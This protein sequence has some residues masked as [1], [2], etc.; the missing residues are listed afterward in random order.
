MKKLFLSIIV[1]GVTNLTFA[2]NTDKALARVRYSFSH[3]QDTTQKDK[4]HTE[5]MLLVIGKNASVY[6]S[7]D[8]INQELQMK[9]KLAEQLKEQ[10]GSGNM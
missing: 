3:I 1:L 10:A 8:K 9:Q 2:Q 4:P 5:N 6:T 7:Y